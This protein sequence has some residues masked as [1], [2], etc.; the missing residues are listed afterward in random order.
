M[1]NF[2]ISKCINSNSRR[3]IR[4]WESRWCQIIDY[5]ETIDIICKGVESWLGNILV[6]IEFYSEPI[7]INT[8]D[9]SRVFYCKIS[10]YNCDV[11][12]TCV[13][14]FYHGSNPD[15]SWSWVYPTLSNLYIASCRLYTIFPQKREICCTWSWEYD[16]Y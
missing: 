3:V 7:V 1:W 13:W 4:I 12:I 6:W 5:K 10:G 2:E 16:S 15:N 14:G 8:I 9:I 11:H